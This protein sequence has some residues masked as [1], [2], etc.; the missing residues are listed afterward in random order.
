[1]PQKARL[2]EKTIGIIRGDG[3]WLRCKVA[4]IAKKRKKSAKALES[5]GDGLA[6]RVRSFD[7]MKDARKVAA[8]VMGKVRGEAPRDDPTASPSKRL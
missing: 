4:S 2:V 8:A 7:A 1:M 5:G 3:T 6:G